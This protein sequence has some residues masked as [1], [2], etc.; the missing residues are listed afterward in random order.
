ML[1]YISAS[2]GTIITIAACI[3]CLQD[4]LKGYMAVGVA[5]IRLVP[6]DTEKLWLTHGLLRNS[7]LKRKINKTVKKA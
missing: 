2:I 6:T 7:E 4:P 3:V 1:C 5:M